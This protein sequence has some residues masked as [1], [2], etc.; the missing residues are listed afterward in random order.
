MGKVNT[1][2]HVGFIMDGNGRW[3]TNQGLNRI[4]GHK[5]GLKSLENLIRILAEDIDLKQASFY[6]FSTENWN[7]P[8]L[9]VKAI[10]HLL[11]EFILKDIE[12]LWSENIEIRIKGDLSENSPFD[13]DLRNMLI[14]INE[15]KIDNP[16]LIINLCINYGG[17]DEIVR[18]TNSLI[19]KNEAIT[20]RSLN[21]EILDGDLDLDLI[22]RTSGENRLSNFLL[23]QSAYAEI[24]FVDYHWPEINYDKYSDIKEDFYDRE[25]R[26][27]KVS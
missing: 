15:K 2:K 23:W 13:E 19:N 25:R 4:D 14:S 1:L 27:G 7:R 8:A 24:L 3:A 22:V 11:K 16:K 26:F 6:C 21:K 9:E 18:A 17:Q 12:K 5:E 10:M 20:V